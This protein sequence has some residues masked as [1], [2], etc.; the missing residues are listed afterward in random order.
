MKKIKKYYLKIR[1]TPCFY[2]WMTLIL[3]CSYTW[4]DSKN[5]QW[6]VKIATGRVEGAYYVYAKEYQKELE[7]FEINLEIIPTQGAREAQEKV[8]HGEADFA[9]V[10]G[11]LESL[12]Q[13][14]FALA[15]VAHEPIWVLTHRESN[16]ITFDDLAGKTINICNSNNGTNPIAKELLN[17]LLGENELTLTEYSASKAFKLLKE[18]KIDAMFYVIARSSSSLQKMIKDENIRIMNFNNA[19]SIRKYFIKNDMNE[20]FNSYYKIVELKKYSLDPKAK[21]P[22]EDKKLLVKRT[23]LVTK[24]ASS[25]MVRLFLKV[26]QKVHS[27][28][29]FFHDENY[30]INSRGLKYPQHR[31]SKRYFEK[32]L[33]RYERTPFITYWVAQ[34]FQKIEDFILIFIVPLALIAYVIEVI[35]PLSKIYTR[36]KINRWYRRINNLDTGI[37]YFSL[38]ELKVKKGLLEELLIEVQDEDGI[39]ATH[40]EAYYSIQHQIHDMLENFTKRIEEKGI[41]EILV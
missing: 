14:I 11:G 23:L 40:L 31:A 18:K 5:V 27:Q 32:P 12:G 37:E 7:K 22:K 33:N 41:K 13:G 30:F 2:C 24:N 26:A 21:L 16:I 29:A 15:N 38:D 35:H 19:E 3:L 9:F 1:N 17:A 20:L 36:R 4:L 25:K 8:I 10:Q 28:E 34:S 6:N 39:E